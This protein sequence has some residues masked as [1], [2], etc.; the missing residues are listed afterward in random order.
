MKFYLF[1]ILFYLIS[2]IKLHTRISVTGFT[3]EHT[4]IQLSPTGRI[5]SA[6]KN[7]TVWV[8]LH[9]FQTFIQNIKHDHYFYIA[10]I[11]R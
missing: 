1:S 4:P 3:M 2:V 7:F 10:G 9:I 11:T 5:D 8:C 6:P